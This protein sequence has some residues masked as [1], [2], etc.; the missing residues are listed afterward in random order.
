MAEVRVESSRRGNA[1]R[2]RR[3]WKVV[4]DSGPKVFR[5]VYVFTAWWAAIRAAQHIARRE[6]IDPWGLVSVHTE[7]P[8]NHTDRSRNDA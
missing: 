3:N 6:P 5:R 2:G 1:R 8:T 7:R 4:D